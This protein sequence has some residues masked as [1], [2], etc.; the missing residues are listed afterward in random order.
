MAERLITT[1]TEFHAL[2]KKVRELEVGR[3]NGLLGS[4][5]CLSKR[6][7]YVIDDSMVDGSA[8]PYTRKEFTQSDWDQAIKGKGL[9]VSWYE[10]KA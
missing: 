1:L 5:H 4:S 2:L 9:W 3:S 6:G 8:T 10:E 7:K